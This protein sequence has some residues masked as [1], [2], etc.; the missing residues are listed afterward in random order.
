MTD[1][2]Y[3]GQAGPGYGASS[4]YPPVTGPGY[5]ASSYAS[6]SGYPAYTMA[7]GQ[8]SVP[9]GTYPTTGYNAEPNYTYGQPGGQGAPGYPQDYYQYPQG[10]PGYDTQPRREPA[11]PGYRVPPQELGRGGHLDDR[12]MGYY[13]ASPSASTPGGYAPAPY[14]PSPSA[15]DQPPV[16]DTYGARQP[17]PQDPHY[18]RR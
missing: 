15:Y 13:D 10:T 4:T 16:R 18:R 14:R 3:A 8:G 9:A 11:G 12:P 6:G 5:P 17:Q 1:Q 7:S 2:Y